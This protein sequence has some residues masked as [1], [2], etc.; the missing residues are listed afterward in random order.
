MV[1]GLNVPRDVGGETTVLC[2]K[3]RFT[4]HPV[5]QIKVVLLSGVRDRG[6]IAARYAACLRLAAGNGGVQALCGLEP[7]VLVHGVER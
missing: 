2:T 1:G 4:G 6:L 5:R 3:Q 7:E